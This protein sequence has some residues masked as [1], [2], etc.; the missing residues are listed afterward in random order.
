MAPFATR[1][2]R[3]LVDQAASGTI[4]VPEF[5]REF[6]W[7]PD[8]V[9]SLVDSVYRDYPI[10]QILMW[11]RPAG[12]EAAEGA[13]SSTE[14][15]VD[16]QQRM[17]ALCLMFDRRPRWWTDEASWVKR[18]NSTDVWVDLDAGPG[19]VRFG[20]VT[21]IRAADPR[22]VS[23][24]RVLNG[25]STSGPGPDG[26]DVRALAEAIA[27]RLPGKVAARLPP[28][29]I[30]ARLS[31]LIELGDRS[32]AVAEVHHDSEDVAEIFT[33]LNQQGTAVTEA[34]V[35]LALAAT[36]SA[37]WV[38]GEFLPFLKNLAESGYRVEPGVALRI[39]VALGDGHVRLEEVPRG[40]WGSAEFGE[41][42]RSTKT[43][44]SGLM[45]GLA[46]AGLL[47]TAILP[48]QTALVPLALLHA[49]HG[50]RGFHLPRAL[51]WLLMA[52]RA[53]RYS[54]AGASTLAEDVRAVQDATDFAEAIQSLRGHLDVELRIAPGEFLERAAW[55]RPLALI[56]SLAWFRRGATDW[57]TKRRLGHG[58]AGET[59]DHGFVP[60]WH[61][62]FPRGRTV[63]RSPRFDY[64]EDE[65]GALANLVVLNARPPDRRWS[66]MVPSRYLAATTVT[67][68]Q[69]DEQLIPPDRALWM[70][71][72]YRD[73]LAVRS[74]LLAEACNGFLASLV[75]SAR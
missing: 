22:W 35:A 51:H 53:A 21:P 66:S 2:V 61:S 58:G 70:P 16:G 46:S 36:Q 23:V 69:L 45:S 60:H 39:V 12:K 47:S 33:R 43:S 28:E 38:R 74:G 42:W 44:L 15:L 37:G 68:A 6:V 7:R 9:V 72:R 63:L 55:N 56:V 65:I 64:S 34:D 50:S 18:V 5:Q 30:R 10:G 17:T 57:V 24:R 31:R 27:R 4:D 73:F 41:A 11:E 54:G 1:T 71:D 67:D 25:R 14:W 26:S 32:V 20:L 52:S 75:G 59:L 3:A 29:A 62:F 19:A 48:S 49:R 40:F 13:S 8:Q